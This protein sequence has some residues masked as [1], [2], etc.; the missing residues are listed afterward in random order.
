MSWYKLPSAYA[1]KMSRLSCKIFGDYYTPPPPKPIMTVVNTAN[2]QVFMAPH[3]QNR[4]LIHRNA[5]LPIDLDRSRNFNYYPAHPQIR[6]LMHT[7]RL[8]GLYRD[9]HMDFV[10]EMKRLRLLRGKKFRVK[11]GGGGKRSKLKE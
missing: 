5:S 9:E 3:I 6:S 1:Q 4:A 2:Y 8:H 7:L 11:G 10:Q